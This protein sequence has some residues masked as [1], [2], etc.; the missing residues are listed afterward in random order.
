MNKYPMHVILAPDELMAIEVWL[1]L[2]NNQDR[3]AIVEQ[4]G[5]SEY[6][7]NVIDVPSDTVEESYRLKVYRF[8]GSY[9][10]DALALATTEA[11][12]NEALGPEWIV[13]DTRQLIDLPGLLK[14]RS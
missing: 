4:V 1:R 9:R 6:H 14:P 10:G 13:E 3:V 12:K 5:F 11:Q 8:I 7:A 2:E